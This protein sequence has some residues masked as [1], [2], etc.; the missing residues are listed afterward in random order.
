[1]IGGRWNDEASMVA[2]SIEREKPFS[3]VVTGEAESW[4]PALD[5]IVGP[6]LLATYHVRGDRE[7]LEVVRSGVADAAVLDDA[8]DWSVDVMRLLRLVRRVN[9]VIPVVIV[10]SRRDRRWLEAALRMA[11]FSVVAKPLQLEELLRLIHRLMDRL[12]VM[13]RGNFDR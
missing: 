1:M 13:L 2:A 11:A 10:S 9:R 8:V 7:L 3:L 5:V 12:D 4:K 6:R